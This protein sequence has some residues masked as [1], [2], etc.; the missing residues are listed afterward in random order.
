MT[1]PSALAGAIAQELV[2]DLSTEIQDQSKYAIQFPA[3]FSEL[4]EQLKFMQSF[5]ADAS[6]LKDKQETV[7]MTLQELQKLIYEA[8]DLVVDCQIREDYT[9]TKASSF[10]LCLS[11]MAFRYK[12]GKKLTEINSHIKRMRENLNSYYTPIAKHSDSESKNG[13]KTLWSSPVFDQ[14]EVVGLTEN[15]ATIRDWILGHNEPLLRLAIVGLGGLGKTTLAKM[16]YRDVNLTKRFQEKIWVS[17]SQ[18]VN[19]TEIMKSMLR[20]LKSDDSG[21]SKGDMLSRISQ[22]LSEKTY[23]IVLDD[24][25][26]IEDGWWERISSGLPKTEGLN[27]CI[28]ITSR[29]KKVVKKMGVRDAQIHRPRLLNDEESWKLFCKVAL[30]SKEDE[31]NTKLIEEGKEIVQ[32]CGGLPLAI[33]TIGGL[34]SSEA[35]CYSEW[36]RIHKNFHEKLTSAEGSRAG[37]NQHVIASLQLSYDELPP[38]LKQCILCFSIYPEDHEV[39]VDQLIRWWEGEGFVRCRSTEAA[40]ESALNCLSELISRCLV[41]VAERRN[42]DGSVYTCKVHDMV[43]DLTIKIAREEDFCSFDGNGKHIANAGSRRL[44]VTKE[45][46]FQTLRGNS[47]LRALLLTATDYIG[48]NSNIELANVKSLRVLD[49]SHVKLDSICMKDLWHWITSLTRLAYLSLRYVAQLS[50]IPNSVGKL[51]G[52]QVLILGECKDLKNLP[53]SIVNLPRLII[54]DVGNCPNLQCLPQGFSRLSKLQ[55]LYGF[56]IAGTGNAAGSHLGELKA[57]TEL[58]VLQMDITEE[59]TINDQELEIL[60]QLEKLKILSINAG[61]CEDEDILSKLNKLSPPS[62]I[63]E[64]YLKHYVGE[65]TPGWINPKSLRQ[66]QYLC[67]EDS[68]INK[69][70]QDFWG[71]EEHKWDVKGLCLKFCQR[72][73]V[74]WEEL[75]AVM[76]EIRHLEVSQCNLLVSFPCD[77]KSV[78]FWCKGEKKKDVRRRM[79]SVKKIESS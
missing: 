52:L 72:L 66:L 12:T 74:S 50:E 78:G 56:K 32:K 20:Q 62:S 10:S 43:R 71:D 21:S 73:E 27:N 59:S 31:E 1:L 7:K 34:L 47:K 53:P 45:T 69:M 67:M 39:D 33:K 63:E 70:N 79:F 35:K 15:V 24:V 64:L 57:L 44:G 2:K 49:F 11:E 38:R 61:D 30:I 9:E 8:D 75:Q 29:I 22:L 76:P 19:E 18:P 41:E 13:R 28:I 54:L 60:A 6:K 51:W 25:W 3:Q 48:F 46:K 17:V 58:R 23:L 42:F 16:I 55:E 40:T 68:R 14:S 5:V 26:S 36:T 65:T 37:G 4:R 77:V